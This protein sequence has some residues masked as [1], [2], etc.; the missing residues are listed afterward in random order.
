[1]KSRRGTFKK[2]STVCGV[3]AAKHK[4]QRLAKEITNTRRITK[5]QQAAR[6][7]EQHEDDKQQQREKQQQEVP[8]DNLVELPQTQTTM[9]APSTKKARSRPRKSAAAAKVAAKRPQ[10][11]ANDLEVPAVV[12]RP[13]KRPRK[14]TA[15]GRNLAVNQV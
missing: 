7:A 2:S 3:T 12:E 9:A 13:G 5:L 1:M 11:T 4:E 6:L 14:L 8:D 10:I 15:K